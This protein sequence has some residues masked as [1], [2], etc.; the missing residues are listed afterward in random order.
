MTHTYG[1][2]LRVG[3]LGPRVMHHLLRRLPAGVPVTVLRAPGHPLDIPDERCRVLEG[4]AV[5][6][7]GLATLAR[8]MAVPALLLCGDDGLIALPDR[9]PSAPTGVGVVRLLPVIG[10]LY[11]LDRA[12]RLDRPEHYFGPVLL[13]VDALPACVGDA[14]VPLDRWTG[15]HVVLRAVAAGLPVANLPAGGLVLPSLAQASGADQHRGRMRARDLLAL[16]GDAQAD[17]FAVLD[18]TSGDGP[19]HG[20]ERTRAAKRAID[21]AL[22]RLTNRLAATLAPFIPPDQRARP[23][24]PQGRLGILKLDSIGDSVLLTSF[25]RPLRPWFG[26]EIGLMASARVRDLVTRDPRIDRTLLVPVRLPWLAPDEATAWLEATIDQAVAFLEGVDATIIPRLMPDYYLANHIAV[27]AGVPRRYGLTSPRMPDL[28]RFNAAFTAM[29]TDVVT[30][31]APCHEV[32]VMGAL[33]RAVSGGG[34]A[35]TSSEPR[36]DIHLDEVDRATAWTTVPPVAGRTLVALGLGASTGR[37]RWPVDQVVTAARTLAGRH[38]LTFALLG[39]TDVAGDAAAVA[40]ALGSRA[41]NLAGRLDLR[42]SAAVLERAALYIG[43]DSGLMHMAA[44]VAVP[45]VEISCHPLT[46]PDNHENAPHRF[47]PVGVPHRIV[48]PTA[49]A[50]PACA[51]GCVSRHT[52]HCITGVSPTEVVAAAETLLA[53]ATLSATRSGSLVE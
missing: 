10:P 45:V 11:R 12:D 30:I 14:P 42:K 33:M 27:L 26:G 52:A 9:R 17:A 31:P 6:A 5:D 32:E 22:S 35:P 3:R 37:R 44:A 43:N 20:E 24:P 7:A 38:D 28:T 41:H 48:R 4:D 40:Q 36:C 18:R 23:L 2:V 39:G 47:G 34:A 49:P 21:A 51:L 46:A 15:H 1:V 25:L 16:A 29:M 50:D 53:S 8:D 19:D 13:P